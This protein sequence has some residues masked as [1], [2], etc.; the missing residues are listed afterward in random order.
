M[1]LQEDGKRDSDVQRIIEG[2]AEFSGAGEDR[3]GLDHGYSFCQNSQRIERH[4]YAVSKPSKNFPFYI[5]DGKQIVGIPDDLNRAP[6]V[7]DEK[8]NGFALHFLHVSK[9]YEQYKAPAED[10]DTDRC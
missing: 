5:D 7:E 4:P 8:D 6:D 9:N 2:E 3:N 10:L 1:E